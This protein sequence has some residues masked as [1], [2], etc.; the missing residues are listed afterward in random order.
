MRRADYR[1]TQSRGVFLVPGNYVEYENGRLLIACLCRRKK[2][3]QRKQLARE[4]AAFLGVFAYVDDGS[5]R[6]KRLTGQRR[7]SLRNQVNEALFMARPRALRA[8][9]YKL[10]LCE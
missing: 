3:Y 6:L 8:K 5:G 10:A 9:S 2:V 4:L 7:G 1:R